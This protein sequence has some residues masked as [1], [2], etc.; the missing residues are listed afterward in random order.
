MP[1]LCTRKQMRTGYF[2][3]W[4]LHNVLLLIVAFCQKFLEAPLS[5][6]EL[7][8]ELDYVLHFMSDVL[9]LSDL[10]HNSENITTWVTRASVLW[11]S[12]NLNL[13]EEGWE[14]LTWSSTTIVRRGEVTLIKC[15]LDSPGVF[16]HRPACHLC[17]D[18]KSDHTESDPSRPGT[19]QVMKH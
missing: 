16:P 14:H 6:L 8:F 10:N 17:I 15:W 7:C 18:T 1:K 4:Q 3:L 12:P 13:R 9:T 11:C 5:V 2:L 19:C